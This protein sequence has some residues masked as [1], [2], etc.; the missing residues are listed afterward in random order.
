MDL[1]ARQRYRGGIMNTE[2]CFELISGCDLCLRVYSLVLARTHGCARARGA[3][4]W[5]D[6]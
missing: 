6:D 2:L 4:L 1:D 5:R 3:I